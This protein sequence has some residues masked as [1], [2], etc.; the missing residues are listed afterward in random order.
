MKYVEINSGLLYCAKLIELLEL[1]MGT[2]DKV[3]LTFDHK[4]FKFT[5]KISL[6]FSSAHLI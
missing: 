4:P 3:G 2:Q 5:Q 1:A 6:V